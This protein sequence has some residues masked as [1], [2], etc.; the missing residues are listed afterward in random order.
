MYVEKI[1]LTNWLRYSGTNDLTLAP[2]VYGVVAHH[3]RDDERSNWLGKT[4]VLAAVRFALFG[5][6]NRKT[7]D[8]WITNGEK[9]GCVSLQLSDGT[10]VARRRV[11]GKATRLVVSV[12]GCSPAHDDDAQL[13]LERRIGMT[14]ADFC[15]T[16]FF[17]QKQINRFVVAK[18][19]DR[20]A[21]IAGWLQ[22]EPLQRAEK[23]VRSSLQ[24]RLEEETKIAARREARRG[25]VA[26]ILGRYFDMTPDENGVVD[27]PPD[28]EAIAELCEVITDLTTVATAAEEVAA[29]CKGA[30]EDI[31]AWRRDAEAARKHRDLIA[32]AAQLGD[33]DAIKARA[34]AVSNKFEAARQGLDAVTG[35]LRAASDKLRQAEQ[36]K[37]GA[38]D[39]KCPVDGHACPDRDAMNGAAALNC[40]RY[41]DVQVAAETI[42][43]RHSLAKQHQDNVVAERLRAQDDASRRHTMLEQAAQFAGAVER[44]RADGLPP[45]DD[46]EPAYR[47]AAAAV[48]KA[49]ADVRDAKR[50]LADLRDEFKRDED[51]RVELATLRSEVVSFQ[52][53]VA[54][55]GRNGAQRRLAEQALDD[56]TAMANDSLREAGIEL[57]VNVSWSR[58]GQ[59]LADECDSCGASFARGR[60]VKECPRCGAARGPKTVD[61]IEVDL[62]DTSGAAED[63]A[64]VAVQLAAGAWLRR[65]RE[66]QWSA[67][68]IDEPFGALDG[69]NKRALAAHLATLLRGRYGFSQALVV[70][71][72]RG[73]MD[74]MPG[75]LVVSATDTA[76]TVAVA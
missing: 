3:E 67:A 66:L 65:R 13:V 36:L 2:T 41:E 60:A 12:P 1:V 24:V 15:A 56:I 10:Q 54:I 18:P 34:D 73:I 26:R 50:S 75:R 64:G 20:M 46:L 52:Q 21:I 62:S 45:D 68:F 48:A 27:V 63:L 44:I 35:E 69:T 23:R 40:K 6:H 8:A 59:G 25:T 74:A 57:S 76:S 7:E 51:D 49:A 31:E 9:E 55:L 42:R 32:T 17:A 33:D 70:A 71:H 22:L 14:D 58:E 29:D 30:W 5:K 47:E 43:A 16:C 38:F 11:R 61:R 53:A 4:S 39:G 19:A 72:D 37:R 28:V